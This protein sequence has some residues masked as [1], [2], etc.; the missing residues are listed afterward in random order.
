[1]ATMRHSATVGML[2]T[3][4][5]ALATAACGPDVPANPDWATDVRPILQ[6]RCVRCHSSPARIDPLSQDKLPGAAAFDFSSDMPLA[7][8]AMMVARVRGGP[9]I[10]MPPPPNAPLEDWQIQILANYAKTHP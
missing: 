4:G 1:M 6:A 9:P 2:M 3:L 10:T 8:F 5:L 7:T